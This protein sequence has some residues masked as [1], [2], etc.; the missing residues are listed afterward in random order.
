M[1]IKVTLRK[2]PISKGRYSL[3]LDFYPAIPHPKTGKPTRREFLN[4]YISQKPKTSI[5]KQY[6]TETLKIGENIKQK[7]ENFLNKPE[8]YSQY[9]KEQLRLKELG[10]QNFVEYFKKL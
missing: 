4:L 3:Y 10:E 5:D 6:N 1:A 8:I 7:K 2:K 9:E